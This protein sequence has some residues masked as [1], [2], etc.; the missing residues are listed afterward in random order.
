MPLERA[1]LPNPTN[2]RRH[3]WYDLRVH[4][5][6]SARGWR[7]TK[8][9]ELWGRH[10]AKRLNSSA[11]G[12]ALEVHQGAKIPYELKRRQTKVCIFR[13]RA[14]GKKEIGI[15]AMC[16]AWMYDEGIGGSESRDGEM[17]EKGDGG[18]RRKEDQKTHPHKYEERI[19]LLMK[20]TYILGVPPVQVWS[21]AGAVDG[22]ESHGTLQ[23]KKSVTNRASPRW[24]SNLLFHSTLSMPSVG[25]EPTLPTGKTYRPNLKWVIATIDKGLFYPCT[26]FDFVQLHR[27]K[28]SRC[29]ELSQPKARQKK[30]KRSSTTA[31][32]EKEKFTAVKKCARWESNP[33]CPFITTIYNE[34]T[35]DI[36]RPPRFTRA[37]SLKIESASVQ[38]FCKPSNAAG[39]KFW[40][41]LLGIRVRA[42]KLDSASRDLAKIFSN[43][44]SQK[45]R[46][47]VG[48]SEV[49][50][51]ATATCEA[52]KEEKNPLSE[53][54]NTL[55][56]NRT[57]W[58]PAYRSDSFRTNERWVIAVIRKGLVYPPASSIDHSPPLTFWLNAMEISTVFELPRRGQFEHSAWIWAH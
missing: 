32:L 40:L 51:A 38:H 43:W 6:Y 49:G 57:H 2:G 16:A 22:R 9:M 54:T 18:K 4:R 34:Y 14:A 47:C 36:G 55:G 3:E 30:T 27:W 13:R 31:R 42:V 39:V 12:T 5:P 37:F 26:E 35:T 33:H 29:S 58:H 52:K 45:P 1:K 21:V 44:D 8:A 56:G 11:R 48:C 41:P 53:L 19:H 25:I 46:R 10:I 7:E 20:S 23:R 17:Q 28:T 15:S 50:E 24:E